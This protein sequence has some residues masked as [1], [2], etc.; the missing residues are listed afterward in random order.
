MKGIED[1]IIYLME[2]SK[3]NIARTCEEMAGY[4]IDKSGFY[5]LDPDGSLK[6]EKAI[7]AYCHFGGHSQT[8]WT[9]LGRWVVG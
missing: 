7:L 9:R 8:M 2:L 5:L 6:G 3:M 4:G 1:D